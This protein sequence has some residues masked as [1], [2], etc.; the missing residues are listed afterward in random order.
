[1][2]RGLFFISKTALPKE[3]GLP[4]GGQGPLSWIDEIIQNFSM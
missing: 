4:M 1:M 3:S 2:L